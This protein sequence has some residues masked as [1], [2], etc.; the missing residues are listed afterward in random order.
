MYLSYSIIILLI[1]IPAFYFVIKSIVAEDVDEDLLLQKTGLK[2]KLERLI[3]LN[4]YDFLA[5]F[6]PNINLTAIND[7]RPYDTL[8]TTSIF[9]TIS[10]EVVPY[11][12]LESSLLIK[13]KPYLVRLKSSL[14]DNDDL[15]L[16]IVTVQAV[17]MLLIIAGLVIINRYYSKRLWNPFYKTLQHLRDYK[18]ET[19]ES[20]Q[21]AKTGIDE[22]TDLNQT[23]NTLTDRNHQVYVSQK[24]FT[25]NASHEMQTPLAVFQSKIE[26]LMQT[27]PLTNEQADLIDKLSQAGLRM[28]RLNKALL[29]LAK[30]DNNQFPDKEQ[31][32]VTETVNKLLAQYNNALHQKNI[33]LQKDSE[34]PIMTQAN[35]TLLE[36][37]I[38]N[39]LSNAIR[40]NKRGGL[41]KISFFD[42]EIKISNEGKDEA[43]DASKLFQRF[44]KQTDD[45][46]SIGLGLEMAKKICR[47]SNFQIDYCYLDSL[48]VFILNFGH[49]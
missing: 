45:N 36:I 33:V 2:N 24:E 17:L 14:V 31:I 5:A 3:D 18:I 40:H 25:E 13:G 49:L 48:H 27:T 1:A 15:I 16:S 20:T 41:L 6:E 21:L 28:N 12:I 23:I 46:N 39:L 9:D 38:G 10:K 19:N 43:L 30:I 29:L 42:K 7:G 34:L 8:Y 47:L 37:L 11:R 35:R 32:N 4:P 22:F 26:L 44:K